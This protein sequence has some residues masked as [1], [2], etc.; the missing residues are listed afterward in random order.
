[1]R[2]FRLVIVILLMAVALSVAGT[3]QWWDHHLQLGGTTSNIRDVDRLDGS[4][5]LYACG[6]N[7][8][9]LYSSYLGYAWGAFGSPTGNNFYCISL[10]EAGTAYAGGAGVLY[11]LESGAWNSKSLPSGMSSIRGIDFMD[12]SNGWACGGSYI[13]RTTSGGGS[14]NSTNLGGG[15]EFYDIAMHDASYGLAVDSGGRIFRWDGSSWT[16]TD[17]VASSLRAVTLSGTSN[18]WAVG[19]GG[20]IY[21]SSNGGLN[22]IQRT[23]GTSSSLNDVRAYNDGGTYYVYAV[24]NNGV[25]LYSS[26]AGSSWNHMSNRLVSNAIYAICPPNDAS[27]FCV[28]GAKGY[29]AITNTGTGWTGISLLGNS[30]YG[31]A[32]TGITPPRVGAVGK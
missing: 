19:V 18:A 17:T 11:K 23:S 8:T 12:A 14:W 10:P 13:A 3:G 20:S 25:G 22:W 6:D 7:G 29:S 32:T 27:N 4:T 30:I 31:V 21:S 26:N 5:W 2:M 28:V 16:N 15:N 24:G 9:L 1:M